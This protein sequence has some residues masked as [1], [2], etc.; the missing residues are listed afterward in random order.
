M[1][2]STLLKQIGKAYKMEH[3]VKQEVHPDYQPT[4]QDLREMQQEHHKL[5]ALRIEESKS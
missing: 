1:R 5:E 2:L 4:D 3:Q